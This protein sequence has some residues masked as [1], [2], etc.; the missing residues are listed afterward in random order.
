[1]LIHTLKK[2]LVQLKHSSHVTNGQ[3]VM[4][5]RARGRETATMQ[6]WNLLVPMCFYGQGSIREASGT[7]LGV[8]G[9][10]N[11]KENKRFYG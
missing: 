2:A 5:R 11:L 6:R 7:A 9:T 10:G 4:Q 8:S 1:M 3:S